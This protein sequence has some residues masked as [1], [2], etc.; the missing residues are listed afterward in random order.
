MN[1][2][3]IGTHVKHSEQKYTGLISLFL[4][5]DYCLVELDNQHLKNLYPF[6]IKAKIEKL[7]KIE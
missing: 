7:I 3:N 2:F 1:N 5:N 4:D 6:G